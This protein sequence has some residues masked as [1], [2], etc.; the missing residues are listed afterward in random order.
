MAITGAGTDGLRKV[1]ADLDKVAAGKHRRQLAESL[2]AESLALI[3]RGFQYSQDPYGK[4][5]PRPVLRDGLPLLKSSRLRNGFTMQITPTR[6]E[7]VNP[8][9]YAKIQNF[10]GTVVPKQKKALRFTGRG[11]TFF[12]KKVVIPARQMVPGDVMP[13]AWSTRLLA[14]ADKV[15]HLLVRAA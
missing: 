4:A 7:A 14:A 13:E 11:K 5:W 2:A 10:G 12:A 3:K 1:I 6:I 9:I 8:T 15:I